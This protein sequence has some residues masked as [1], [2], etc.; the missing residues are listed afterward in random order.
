MVEREKTG[1]CSVCK[2]VTATNLYHET[3][4]YQAR[5]G[6]KDKYRMSAG[7]KKELCR[8][9]FDQVLAKE[10]LNYWKE[11]IAEEQRRTA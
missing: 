10:Q 3:P 8:T 6:F 2:K 9:C 5:D 11:H 4:D 1:R 7:R